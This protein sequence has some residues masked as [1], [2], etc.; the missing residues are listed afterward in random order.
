MPEIHVLLFCRFASILLLARFYRR[1]IEILY[2]SIYNYYIKTLKFLSF[3]LIF[4]FN[5]FFLLTVCLNL[6]RILLQMWWKREVPGAYII[7]L[8]LER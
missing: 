7:H 1:S 6:P 2:F 5:V 4:Y 8:R 3:P